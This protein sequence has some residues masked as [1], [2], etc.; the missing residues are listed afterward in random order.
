MHLR[1]S[2]G[3]HEQGR[4]DRLQGERCRPGRLRVGH[5]RGWSRSRGGSGGPGD[6]HGRPFGVALQLDAC[7]RRGELRASEVLVGEARLWPPRADGV[8]PNGRLLQPRQREAAAQHLATTLQ[9]GA[10]EF[11]RLIVCHEFSR[12]PI[13]GWH[14]W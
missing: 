13:H 4:Q 7:E 3:A 9:R 11:S 14:S 10:V 12:L 8:Y 1:G 5:Q 6:Q 2:S